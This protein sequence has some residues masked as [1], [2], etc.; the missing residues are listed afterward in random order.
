MRKFYSL[1]AVLL[2][3]F[4]FIMGA[5]F[6]FFFTPPAMSLFIASS[7]AVHFRRSH[8]AA[9]SITRNHFV[10]AKIAVHFWWFQ[11]SGD[12]A[13]LATTSPVLKLQCTFGH[14][15]EMEL[16]LTR[17]HFVC[18]PLLLLIDDFVFSCLGTR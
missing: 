6:V 15:A 16:S 4:Q 1:Y 12:R 17:N 13:S 10:C 18:Y 14:P 9:S 7:V 11:R 8:G 2:D 3:A 5:T